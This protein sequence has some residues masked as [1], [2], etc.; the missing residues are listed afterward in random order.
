MPEAEP[1][2]TIEYGELRRPSHEHVHVPLDTIVGKTVVAVGTTTV[3]GAWGDE[4]CVVLFFR[5]GTRHWFVLPADDDWPAG[6]P[7]DVYARPRPGTAPT[8]NP[9]D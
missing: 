4:P 9:T 6:P 2:I 5:D 1:E 3:A 7:G 8:P